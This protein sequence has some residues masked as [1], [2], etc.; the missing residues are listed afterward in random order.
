MASNINFDQSGLSGAA[1]QSAQKRTV[2]QQA[3]ST[4]ELG[5]EI[6]TSLSGRSVMHCG[7]GRDD[8]P[9][10]S[11]IGG[12]GYALGRCNVQTNEIDNYHRIPGST[13]GG[14]VNVVDTEVS[15]GVE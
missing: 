4:Q 12:F 14:T 10:Q 9:N 5:S 7:G 1:R 13:E 6:G 11:I 2:N 8:G 3:E 15:S